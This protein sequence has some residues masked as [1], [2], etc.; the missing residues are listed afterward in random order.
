MWADTHFKTPKTLQR[1]RLRNKS[2]DH[3][4]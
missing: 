3:W 1:S 4:N 2:N